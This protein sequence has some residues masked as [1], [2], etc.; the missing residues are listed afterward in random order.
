MTRRPME[1]RRSASRLTGPQLVLAI[2]V[3]VAMISGVYAVMILMASAP[4]PEPPAELFRDAPVVAG[5]GIE[6]YVVELVPGSSPVPMDPPTFSG[7][8]PTNEPITLRLV[9]LA[10][11]AADGDDLVIIW[12]RDEEELRRSRIVLRPG[13]GAGSAVLSGTQ[14]GEPGIYSVE[15]LV[16]DTPLHA[17]R[18]D[19]VELPPS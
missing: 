7:E 4:D 2:G 10:D 8:L 18:F 12:T 17:A 5:D 13:R 15:I 9:Y 16:E 19:V 11:E 3:V 6:L 1:Q 14:T